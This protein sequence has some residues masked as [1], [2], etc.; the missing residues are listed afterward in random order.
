MQRTPD[1]VIKI[2]FSQW[3]ME[4]SARVHQQSGTTYRILTFCSTPTYSGNSEWIANPE[5]NGNASGNIV[6][7]SIKNYPYA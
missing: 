5:A 1:H 4:W 6:E 2:A 3:A 7:V